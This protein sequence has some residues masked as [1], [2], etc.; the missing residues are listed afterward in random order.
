MLSAPENMEALLRVLKV[1]ANPVRLRMIA[2]LQE[3]PMHI[4]ALAK[5][6]G[7]SYPLAHL[8]LATLE[9]YG[10]VTGEIKM[11]NDDERERKEYKVTPFQV[12]LSPEEIAKLAKMKGEKKVG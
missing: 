5:E 11:G 3:Q 10:I 2:L 6:L 9:K 7:L 1:L 4:Y 8:Y 12:V